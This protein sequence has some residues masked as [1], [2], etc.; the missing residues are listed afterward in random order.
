MGARAS[1]HKIEL[2]V[3]SRDF[4]R[5]VGLITNYYDLEWLGLTGHDFCGTFECRFLPQL[6]QFCKDNPEYHI[7]TSSGPG[8]LINCLVEGN[9]FYKVGDGDK[10]PALVLN[11]LLDPQWLVSYEDGISSALAELDNVKNRRK[12]K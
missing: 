9:D 5:R 11:Y 1:E 12:V 3:T 10:D 2:F 6:I 8:R 7:L 4:N